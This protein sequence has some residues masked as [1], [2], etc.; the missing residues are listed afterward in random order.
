MS[1]ANVLK[2]SYQTYQGP[3]GEAGKS[4]GGGLSGGAMLPRAFQSFSA[5]CVLADFTGLNL[6]K[7]EALTLISKA[8]EQI[9][10]VKFT[11][12]GQFVE[13][14]FQSGGAVMAALGKEL[15]VGGIVVPVTRCFSPKQSILPVAIHG[16]PI[17]PKEDTY[18]ELTEV[19]GKFGNV[20]ELKFHCYDKTNIRMDSC[21]VLLDR[22]DM[23]KGNVAMPRR[24][25]VFGKYCDL[26]WREAKPFCRYCKDEGHFVQKCPKLEK[27]KAGEGKQVMSELREVGAVVG[28][29]VNS[30][31]APAALRGGESGAERQPQ[32]AVMETDEQDFVQASPLME[33]DKLSAEVADRFQTPE[34]VRCQD[35]NGGEGEIVMAMDLMPVR[36]VSRGI[37]PSVESNL[38]SSP[39]IPLIRLQKKPNANP[40]GYK[41]VSATKKQRIGRRVSTL[42]FDLDSVSRADGIPSAVQVGHFMTDDLDGDEVSIVRTPGAPQGSIVSDDDG[43]LTDPSLDGDDEDNVSMGGSQSGVTPVS[44]IIAGTSSQV[45]LHSVLC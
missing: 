3:G 6:S 30:V 24:V 27:K 33:K 7:G 45:E 12:Q 5:N 19:F 11:K 31:Y 1:F 20:Q 21:S 40:E 35:V 37:S 4:G 36:T 15:Q 44:E 8:Y 17:Y 23:E 10:G 13:V 42:C 9:E 16:I 14:A 41:R 18:K 25:E 32:V 2:R 39:E 29:S 28:G 22:S 34:I 43:M 26:F 38:S